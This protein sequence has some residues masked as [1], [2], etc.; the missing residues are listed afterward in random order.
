MRKYQ[1]IIL[2]LLV[3][4]CSCNEEFIDLEIEPNTACTTLNLSQEEYLSII[5]SEHHELSEKDIT[6][7][8]ED[9]LQKHNNAEQKTGK[10]TI[11]VRDFKIKTKTKYFINSQD[12]EKTNILHKKHITNLE[13]AIYKAFFYHNG[14]TGLVVISADSRYPSV[15]AFIPKT[16]TYKL[17]K[18]A[19]FLLSLSCSGALNEIARIDYIVDS[20]SL[21]TKT[22]IENNFTSNLLVKNKKHKEFL[23]ENSNLLSNNDIK[24][25]VTI[26]DPLYDTSYGPFGV[27]EWSQSYP[28]NKLLPIDPYWDW[29][30]IRTPAGCAITAGSQLL[31]IVKPTMT[32]RGISI[33]WS[34][35]TQRNKIYHS[36]YETAPL[37]PYSDPEDKINMVANLIYDMYTV[38]GTYPEFDSNGSPIQSSTNATNLYNYLKTHINI[39]SPANPDWDKIKSSIASGRPVLLGGVRDGDPNDPGKKPSHAWVAHGCR[40]LIRIQGIFKWH[41]KYLYCSMGW[42]GTD[43]GWFNAVNFSFNT[44]LGVYRYNMWM[45]TNARKK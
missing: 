8:F 41:S 27:T 36:G 30:Y 25:K 15:L 45:M 19:D 23:L 6:S 14:D 34:Y 29:P 7:I 31:A 21:N 3:G 20:L 12:I 44:N 16:N 39:D 18:E 42:G 9:F 13:L 17:S 38:T 40:E 2:S 37:P 10:K 11:Q 24:T 35:L 43:S 28:Y 22:K 26:D 4:I 32:V 1:F 5:H 33:N